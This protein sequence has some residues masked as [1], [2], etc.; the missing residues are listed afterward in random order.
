MDVTIIAL[1]NHDFL[2]LFFITSMMIYIVK[3]FIF[4][5]R[6]RR[7]YWIYPVFVFYLLALIDYTML[8]IFIYGKKELTEFYGSVARQSWKNY[9]QLIPFSSICEYLTE[10][11]I[12]QIAG[13]IIMLMP[14][15]CFLYLLID[16]I[17]VKKII[18]YGSMI[19]LG[20]ELIQF[21]ID[22]LTGYAN[23]V[24][25]IDDFILNSVGV[26]I[27]AGI[28]GVFRKVEKFHKIYY[29]LVYKKSNNKEIA[30]ER[31]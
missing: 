1:D 31:E 2:L 25:D 12:Y 17:S 16:G 7:R 22:L 23:R 11:N 6:Q 10:G 9:S 4:E 28:I 20:I 29:N 30:T 21:C 18:L 5:K 14:M 26:I 24:C 19:S 27:A 13:N 3:Y 8:P 15:S